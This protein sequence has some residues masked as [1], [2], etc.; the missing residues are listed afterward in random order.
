[1]TLLLA[2]I[3]ARYNST[4]FPGK[5]LAPLGGKT[6]L[7]EVWNRAGQADRID[8][9]VI[10]T[11]DRRIADAADA[12][13][14]EVRM[15]SPD[16]ASGTDRVAEVV[17]ESEVQ[18][19]QYDVVLNIQG[20][21][22]LLTPTSLERLIEPFEAPHPPRMTTLAEPIEDA[23]DLFDPNV[24]KVRDGTRWSRVCTSPARRSPFT[25]APSAPWG[26]IF[27]TG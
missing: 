25:A 7:E 4:R 12:F 24:V 11:D 15:T 20:D 1:M 16:H 10:A 21:E 18:E 23:D 8:R 27:A 2:V 26:T 22:P 13:G 17:R 14:A 19:V 6:M 9:L 5:A 3:P